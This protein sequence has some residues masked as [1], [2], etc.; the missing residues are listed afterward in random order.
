ML[1]HARWSLRTLVMGGFGV[2]SLSLMGA[3]GYAIYSIENLANQSER[4][5][6]EGVYTTRLIDQLQEQVSDLQRTAHQY[7]IVGTEELQEIYEL[8][9]ERLTE[10][11]GSLKAYPWQPEPAVVLEEISA[12]SQSGLERVR[13]GPEGIDAEV[14]TALRTLVGE[15][16]VAGRGNID[17]AL[18]VLRSDVDQLHTALIALALMLT[19]VAVVFAAAVSKLVS[20][21]IDQIGA[22]IRGLGRANFDAPIR[23][24]GPTDLE[25]IG[26]LL[27]WLRER[28]KT[29]EEQKVTFVRHMS[30]EL[31]TP[32]ANIREG[33]ELLCDDLERQPNE[34]L[35]ELAAI[36]RDNGVRLQKLIDGLL[37][38]AAWHEDSSALSAEEFELSAVLKEVLSDYRLEI[39]THGLRVESRLPRQITYFGDRARIQSL[40]DNLLSNAVKYSPPGGTIRVEMGV[41]GDELYIDVRDEGPGIPKAHREKV[42]LPFFQ[43]RPPPSPSRVRGTGIGLSVARAC[44]DAHGGEI[45]IVDEDGPGTHIQI[46][47][48]KR[49][50]ANGA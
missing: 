34:S 15:M 4:V 8:R 16:Q 32:L 9:H 35:K 5:L 26:Q 12:R 40:L 14:Y 50:A 27:D 43:G 29:L 20:R 49:A 23:V 44:V 1:I 3:T 45:R 33:S 30:H 37:N 10:T 47:L 2:A 22:G 41:H 48:P 21:P 6:A 38:F 24:E 28:L 11:I 7:E 25:A 42:F 39:A 36:V 18:A 31:K 17:R 19:S 13:S 46:R